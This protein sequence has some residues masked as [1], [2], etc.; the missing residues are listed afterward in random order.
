M[1]CKNPIEMITMLLADFSYNIGPMSVTKKTYWTIMSI[2]EKHSNCPLLQKCA[3][4]GTVQVVGSTHVE[5][6]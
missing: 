5:H 2:E 1:L 6:G 3:C 4:G